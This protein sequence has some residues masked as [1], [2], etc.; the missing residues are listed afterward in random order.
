MPSPGTVTDPWDDYC[1]ATFPS[2]FEVRDG[3]DQYLFDIHA[4][5]RFL[6]ASFGARVGVPHANLL[7]LTDAGPSEFEIEAPS[8]EQGFP[9]ESP[10]TADNIN[11]YYAV[12]ADVTVYPTSALSNLTMAIAANQT[13][14]GVIRI[15]LLE[16]ILDTR[17][18][19]AD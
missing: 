11:E 15:Q 3:S 2:E 19:H 9:F 13:R 12:F 5:D 1:V 8:T 7:Y 14:I 16:V 4:G 6:L 18:Q 10:C 17:V